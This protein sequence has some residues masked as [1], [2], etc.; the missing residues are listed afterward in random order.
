[1]HNPEYLYLE[2]CHFILT[3]ICIFKC[4]PY[5][6]SWICYRF[7]KTHQ[8]QHWASPDSKESACNAGYLGSIPGLGRCPGEGNGYPFQCSC[9]ENSM[10]RGACWATVHEVTHS[11]TRLSD[12]H[13]TNLTTVPRGHEL[14]FSSKGMARPQ[15]QTL[16]A[17][18]LRLDGCML[19]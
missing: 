16:P 18:S 6:S 13:L 3:Q 15:H 10:N 19:A 12:S 1:M 11:Q 17:S 4:L 2:L 8:V 5:T 14:G 9:L 7:L